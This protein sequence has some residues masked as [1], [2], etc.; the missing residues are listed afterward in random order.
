LWDAETGKVQKDVEY[1]KV[2]DGLSIELVLDPLASRFV[3]FRNNSSGKNDDGLSYNL[4]YGFSNHTARDIIDLSN[5]WDV[6]FDAEMGAPESYQF[7]KLTSWTDVDDKGINY[8][9][10]SANYSR[11]FTLSEETLSKGAQAYI[12][13]EDIQEMACVTVNGND[14]G[15][16]WT[17]PYKANITQY[18]KEGTNKITVQVINNWNNRI[19]GDLKNPDE[20]EYTKTNAKQKFTADDPLLESGLIGKAEL[21]FVK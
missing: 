2:D 19:V 6:E 21:L 17:P 20:K 1:S 14:C 11:D 10:G 3:V 16:V 9:S 13:F 8:Y 7:D 5:D 12:T 15:I 4:Q 18:L